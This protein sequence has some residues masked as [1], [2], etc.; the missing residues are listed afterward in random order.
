M[1]IGNLEKFICEYSYDGE[2]DI[3]SMES[4][5]ASYLKHKVSEFVDC[6]KGINYKIYAVIEEGYKEALFED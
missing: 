6:G 4:S 5:S 3:F 1:I 2:D